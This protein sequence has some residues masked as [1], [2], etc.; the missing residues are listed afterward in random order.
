MT[1]AQGD[2]TPRINLLTDPLFSVDDDRKL[3]LPELFAGLVEGRVAS[4]ARLRAHQRTAW[5]MFSV[6]LA[7][8]ALDRAG[9][10]ELPVSATDWAT[11]LRGLSHADTGIEGDAPWQLVAEDRSAPAFLQPPDPGGLKWSPVATPDAL[12][13]LITSKN[14]D[15]KREIAL[16]ADAE[17]WVFAL[18]SLQT[19]EGYGGSA[20]YGIARMNGGSSSRAFMGLIPAREDNTPDPAAWW[21]RDVSLCLA[22]RDASGPMTPGKTALLWCHPWPENQSLAVTELDTLAIEVCR[23][24]RLLR[25]AHGTLR[26]ERAGSRSARVDASAFRGVLG[27]PWAPVSVDT[28]APKALT[29]SEGRFDYRRLVDLLLSGNW[30]LPLAARLQPKE[31]A[32]QMLLLTEAL[33]RGNSATYGLRSRLLPLPRKAVARGLFGQQSHS[34]SAAAERQMSEIATADAALREAVALYAADGD[35][36][37]VGRDERRRASA[38]RQRLDA[39]AD[40]L[41]FDYL[42]DR[43]DPET[44]D[45]AYRAFRALLVETSRRE[46]ARAFEAIP[47]ASVWSARARVRAERRLNGK[48]RQG[49]LI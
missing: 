4:L 19:M 38:A 37:A 11:L 46:L 25:T 17:D 28:K 20:N 14:H 22:H 3:S 44:E 31:S 42:W 43:A 36:D 49:E 40:T 24:I 10:Q 21:R 16:S 2:I 34:L 39:A 26:A 9:R 23:R 32:D 45:T 6:Q 5:H 33:A 13:L 48:L 8:L 41:F 29:I 18:I 1:D 7:A 47:C 35:P 30:V 27:D 15:L 12:D